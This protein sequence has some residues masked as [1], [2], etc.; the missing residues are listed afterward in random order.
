M[1]PAK[2]KKFL[3][4]SGIRYEFIEHKTVY[5]AHDKAVTLRLPERMVGKTLVV[6]LDKESA[7]VTIPANKNLDKN[8]LK[9][10]AKSK[11]LDFVSEKLMKKKL[12]GIKM[13]AVPPFGRLLKMRT[14]V[15][16]GL[17]GNKKIVLNSGDNNWS[18]K[19]TPSLYKKLVPDLILGSFGRKK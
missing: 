1:V 10:A 9:K 13:G 2:I 5:T 8:K 4:A 18:I 16:R 15:D 7:L 11:K 6:K 3:D 12:K 17:M 14:F 19:I